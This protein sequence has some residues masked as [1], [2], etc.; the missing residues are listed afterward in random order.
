MTTAKSNQRKGQDWLDQN[1]KFIESA[2]SGKIKYSKEQRG[3]EAVRYTG[4]VDGYKGEY[5]CFKFSVVACTWGVV[6]YS[7]LPFSIKV[8]RRKIVSELL[9]RINAVVRIGHFDLDFLS[10]NVRFRIS[11]PKVL[12]SKESMEG[13][14]AMIDLL[15]DRP[16]RIMHDWVLA[17]EKL[18]KEKCDVE[19]VFTTTLEKYLHK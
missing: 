5:N 4:I 19:E 9:T 1:I 2:L 12:I 14:S 7:N 17:I 10:G 3:R 18:M 11:I 13:A 16:S 8:S 15:V 6:A